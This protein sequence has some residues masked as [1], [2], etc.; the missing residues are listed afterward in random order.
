[1]LSQQFDLLDGFIQIS[2]QGTSQLHLI[3]VASHAFLTYSRQYHNVCPFFSLA[4][5]TRRYTR[6]VKGRLRE[7]FSPERSLGMVEIGGIEQEEWRVV[8][9]EG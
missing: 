4:R 3:S 7:G 6:S 5:P 8:D 9:E 1:M 2:N